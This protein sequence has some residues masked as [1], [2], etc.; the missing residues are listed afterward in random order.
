MSDFNKNVEVVAKNHQL[1]RI[2][3]QFSY[4][5]VLSNT[6]KQSTIKAEPKAEYS[7]MIVN[8]SVNT[9]VPDK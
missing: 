8:K 3:Q 1:C 4:H 6:I 2:S 5:Q 7:H 9:L